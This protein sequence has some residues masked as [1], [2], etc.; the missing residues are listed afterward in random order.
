MK[1]I[2]TL[3][4]KK[5]LYHNPDKKIAGICPTGLRCTDVT[6]EHHSILIEGRN[7]EEIKKKAND[8]TNHITRIEVFK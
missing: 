5:N 7:L 1:A 2:V 4:F 6:G 3:K 8:I